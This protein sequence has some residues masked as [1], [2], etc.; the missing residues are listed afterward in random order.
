[1]PI[2]MEKIRPFTA[3]APISHLNREAELRLILGRIE[4]LLDVKISHCSTFRGHDEEKESIYVQYEGMHNDSAEKQFE[5][6]RKLF[7][8]KGRLFAGCKFFDFACLD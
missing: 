7:D 6:E 3:P 8:G 1:M 5:L 2:A 4:G